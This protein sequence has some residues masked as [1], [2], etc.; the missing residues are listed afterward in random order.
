MAIINSAFS[1]GT[2]VVNVVGQDDNPQEVSLHNASGSHSIWIGDSAV[3]IANGFQ[4][5]KTEGLQIVVAPGDQL[6]AISDGDSRDLR[7]LIRK[8]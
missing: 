2:V 7:V 3:T 4:I 8:T 1:V 6:Y 5:E